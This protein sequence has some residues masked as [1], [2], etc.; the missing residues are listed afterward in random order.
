MME[1]M[2]MRKEKSVAFK[3]TSC[4]A[5]E[6]IK[7]EVKKTSL[8]QMMNTK[9]WLCMYVILKISRRRRRKVMV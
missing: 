4:K 7:N 3:A 6:K 1:T 9:R 5:R 2:K 8:A